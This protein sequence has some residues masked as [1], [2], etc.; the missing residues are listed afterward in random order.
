MISH[1]WVRARLLAA[2]LVLLACVQS[3]A[4]LPVFPGAVGFGTNTAA[5]RG[6]AIVRVTNLNDTGAGSLRDAV[7]NAAYGSPR[8]VIFDVSGIIHLQ[9]NIY[10]SIPNVTVAGQ[11]APAPGIMI[12]GGTLWVGASNVLIQHVSAR[13]GNDHP[14]SP[15]L[16]TRSGF[17]IDANLSSGPVENVV[18]DHVSSAWGTDQTFATWSDVSANPIRNVTVSNSIFAEGLRFS[19]HPSDTGDGHSTGPL[20]GRGTMGLTMLRSVSAFNRW[21]NPLVRDSVTDVQF[22]NNLVFWG[23][24]DERTSVYADIA[25]WT[26]TSAFRGNVYFFHPDNASSNFPYPIRAKVIDQDTINLFVEDNRTYNYNVDDALNPLGAPFWAPAPGADP[27]SMVK[28]LFPA[29]PAVGTINHL[30][31]QPSNF[32][33]LPLLSSDRVEL[34]VMAD[35]GARPAFRDSVDV[36]VLDDVAARVSDRGYGTDR[37][38]IDTPAD[39]GGYP[40]WTTVTR[41][42][43]IATPANP[44]AD[45]DGDGYTNLEEWLH[46]LAYRLEGDRRVAQF[47]TFE[48]G[49]SSGWYADSPAANWSVV[50]DGATKVFNQSANTDGQQAFLSKTQFYDQVVQAKVKVTAFNTAGY[51]DPFMRVYARYTDANNNYYVT[52]RSSKKVELKKLQ[53]GTPT[54]LATASLPINVNDWYSVRLSATGGALSVTVKNLTTAPFASV[55]LTYADTSP[56]PPGYAGVGTF[57]TTASFDDVYA[58]PAASS[59]PQLTDD[60]ED[61]SATD[62]TVSGGTWSVLSSGGSNVYRQSDFTAALL[63]RASWNTTVAGADQAVQSTVKVLAFPA[64]SVAS[65]VS[66]HARYVDSVNNYY[67]T[68][69]NTKVFELKKVQG[70]VVVL[71]AAATLPAAFNL[72]KPHVLRIQVTGTSSPQ[73]TGYLDGEPLLSLTDTSGTPFAAAGKAAVG[74]LSA[75]AEFDD[76]VVSS[77]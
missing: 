61:G 26:V 64:T 27:W 77:P 51:S 42:P 75:T 7:K 25:N 68:L 58:S 13:V 6:G 55:T 66:V 53:D 37:G 74:T 35:A 17:G 69:R 24:Y 62:W 59:L 30:T 32:P 8:V 4:A 20:F 49:N 38:Y 52:L 10:L 48:D 29:P 36:R 63:A 67:V 43:G 46:D 71:T 18:F 9:T 56:R 76:V 33:A 11:T 54:T 60:F 5:G 16:Q 44:S 41:S 34:A 2:G 40:N 15:S 45:D 57:F 70:G 23:R 22:A 47:D 31:S 21:R 50:T 14:T 39:V 28:E 19:G 12:E 65:F 73:L 72:S 3:A 1:R